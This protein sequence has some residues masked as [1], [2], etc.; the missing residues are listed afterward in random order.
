VPHLEEA[1][2]KDEPE[3]ELEYVTWGS[4]GS[5]GQTVTYGMADLTVGSWVDLGRR[6][7]KGERELRR[8]FRRH[9]YVGAG[10]RGRA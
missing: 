8:V 4:A 1:D 9:M 2:E 7:G 5:A 3:F 10:E 6:L